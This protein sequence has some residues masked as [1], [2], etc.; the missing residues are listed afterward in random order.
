MWE[1]IVSV[2]DHCLSFYFTCTSLK[3]RSTKTVITWLNN[4]ER[5][6]LKLSYTVKS[7]TSKEGF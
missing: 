3:L 7:D 2:P 1:L 6:V 4:G 5:T